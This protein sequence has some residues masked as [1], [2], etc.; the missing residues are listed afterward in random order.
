[1]ALVIVITIAGGVGCQAIMQQAAALAPAVLEFIQAVNGEVEAWHDAG[2]L[3]EFVWK[4]YTRLKD[5]AREDWDA[6]QAAFIAWVERYLKGEYVIPAADRPQA[7]PLQP[8]AARIL[9]A[10]EKAHGSGDLTE[11]QVVALRA[12]AGS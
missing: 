3:P 8:N 6:G 11:V 12:A 9:A 1:M 10:A 5:Q 2:W 4:E 7:M